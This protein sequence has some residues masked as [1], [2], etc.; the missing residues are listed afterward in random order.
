MALIKCP[1]CG[2]ENVSD[3]ALACPNCGFGIREYF[4]NNKGEKKNSPKA[5]PIKENGTKTKV[6]RCKKCGSI[7]SS[8]SNTCPSCGVEEKSTFSI[9]TERPKFSKG[10]IICIVIGIFV[11]VLGVTSVVRNETARTTSISNGNGDPHF[12]GTILIIFGIVIVCIPIYLYLKTLNRYKLK[13]NNPDLY[14]K[15]IIDENIKRQNQYKAQQQAEKARLAKLPECPICKSKINVKRITS[16]DRSVS[17][18]MVGLASSK[19]GKQ[20]ECTHCKHKF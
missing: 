13:I 10:Y 18:A 12:T 20:Y 6:V 16:L 14:N 4:E 7:Y 8:D 15:I 11:A 9:N 1:E 17:V 19:I 2:R 5:E 3:S